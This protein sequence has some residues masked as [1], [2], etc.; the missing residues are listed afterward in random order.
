MQVLTIILINYL[1]SK[2]EKI[3]ANILVLN[4]QRYF[5]KICLL[6]FNTP[7]FFWKKASI[8]NVIAEDVWH[9]STM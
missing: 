8:N 5:K 6:I 7:N 2:E 9:G 4:I 3:R 1:K